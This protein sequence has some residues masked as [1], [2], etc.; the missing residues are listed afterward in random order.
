MTIYL[1]V[2]L[3]ENLFMNYVILFATSYILKIKIHHI[4]IILSATIGA[5]YAIIAYLNIIPIYSNIFMKIILSVIMVY[6]AYYA[7][8][9]KQLLKQVML[10]YL[11]SFV[12]GGCAFS[13]LYFVQPQ[14]IWIQNGMLMGTYPIKIAILGA[15]LGFAISVL[16]FKLVKSK[17]SKKDMF[18]ELTIYFDEKSS[19]M[20][21]MIDTGNILKEPIT[22]LPV[23]IVEKRALVQLLPNKILENTEKILGGDAETIESK[24]ATKLKIIP[25]SSVGRENGILLGF[26]PDKVLINTEENEELI[27]NVI[28]AIYNKELSRK[29]EY[30]ALLGLDIFE[31]RKENESIKTF[32]R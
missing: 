31:R 30:S 3:L 29:N 17:F 27:N 25:F 2:V 26:K 14:D 28:I 12:F 32:S 13:L 22:K 19:K 10:F 20:K 24:Y 18:C 11:I 5:I 15:L 16:T 7:K 9:I 21:A 1:D 6:V 4:R 8:N 23:I